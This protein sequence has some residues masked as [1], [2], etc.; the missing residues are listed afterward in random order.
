MGNKAHRCALLQ[1]EHFRFIK[2]ESRPNA[3]GSLTFSANFQLMAAMN[4]CPYGWLN[5]AQ[6][7]CGC[8]PAV[9]TKY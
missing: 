9:I 1:N 7:A 3:K 5:D 8:A 6:K 4:P 2:K